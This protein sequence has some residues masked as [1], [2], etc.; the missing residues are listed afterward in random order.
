MV[1][2]TDMQPGA[3]PAARIT[4]LLLAVALLAACGGGGSGGGGASRQ[5]LADV[6]GSS[7]G[8]VGQAVAEPPGVRVV[9]GSGAPVSGATVTF[10][11]EQVGA[12]VSPTTMTTNA[13]GR[14]RPSSW[15]LGT[16]AGPNTLVASA[17]G[18]SRQVSFSATAAAGP[19]SAIRH[20]SRVEQTGDAGLPVAF[21]PAVRVADSYD[22]PVAGATVSFAVQQGGGTISAASAVSDA[23]GIARLES[24]VLGS[25][26]GLNTLQA[27]LPGIGNLSFSAEALAPLELSIESVQL[28]QATQTVTG[29][30]AAV[31]GR[32]GLLR[33]VVR[34]SRANTAT[35]DVRLRLFRDGVQLWERTISPPSGSVP[36]NPSLASLS[37]T[38][39]IALSA[40]EVQPGL[41]VEAVV[42]PQQQIS[43]P[44]RENTRFP[45]GEGQAPILVR[46]L[47]P[48]RV[49]FI[50]IQA[51]RHNATGQIFPSTVESFLASTRLWLP[52]G[53]L[54]SELRGTPFVTDRDLTDQDEISSLLSD[55]QAARAMESAGDRYYHGIM[56]AVNNIPISGIAFRPTSPSSSFRSALSY[57][58]LPR[59]AETVAHELGHNLGR[60]HSPCG[61][62]EG[63]DP[64]FPHANG[65]IGETGYD[66]VDGVLRGPSGLSDYMGY[67]TPR[68]TSD[69]TYR[70]ILE[71][72]RND[73]LAVGAD[74]GADPM[75]ATLPGK[76]SGLLLW[77][78]INDL[79]VELNPAFELAARP[80]L[81]D[82]DGPQL[83][84]G[85]AIDGSVLFE[86]SFEG[87]VVPHARNPTERQFAWFVP[88]AAAQL[89]ALERI[90]LSSP[91]GFAQYLARR[92]AQP[93]GPA[94]L[95]ATA[96][97]AAVQ[98]RLP[99]GEL[100]LRWDAVRNP[101]AV[102]RDRRTGQ[103]IGIGRSGELRLAAETAAGL[104]PEWLF[105]DGVRSR[106]VV[107]VQVQ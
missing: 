57:D 105:S 102:L 73:P 69:Y 41:A 10:R 70:N 106:V 11:V 33:V 49:L 26:L 31:A 27:T 78:R 30:I 17:A 93:G 100:R 22:N 15:V 16:V 6:P 37:Q 18:I 79:G 20:A 86:L 48:L 91:H 90:E 47:P 53:A 66:I 44:S 81:P 54:E 39:N 14:A 94:V 82:A 89:G 97:G 72:R 85:I 2:L 68:W 40:A 4:A 83:L 29:D 67:C 75:A 28:N 55:L 19:A 34:A 12:S 24:W 9:D 71:W 76:E 7:S 52:V 84:R 80:V 3:R 59:A 56:P 8:V 87:A 65:G 99:G 45:R 58:R 38:W 101:V 62:V 21:P 36:L 13:D 77:G 96:D 92:E 104:D 1:E 50:P 74:G 42:D 23:N 46:D 98:E 25:E 35:P 103:V 51:T 88:L 63:A 43:L 61:D 95:A 107:P 32:P 60:E 5:L 64:S